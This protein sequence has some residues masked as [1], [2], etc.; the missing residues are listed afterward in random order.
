MLVTSFTMDKP[1]RSTAPAATVTVVASPS[2]PPGGRCFALYASGCGLE[3]A[4]C[5]VPSSR[6]VDPA[7]RTRT[8]EALA[9]IQLQRCVEGFAPSGPRPF[10][11]APNSERWCGRRETRSS[12]TSSKSG[13]SSANTSC[14]ASAKNSHSG[15]MHVHCF[16]QFLWAVSVLLL[17]NA[18][19][20]VFQ[21]ALTL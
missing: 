21:P 7:A 20:T 18:W 15:V 17:A 8:R 13:C 1:L 3:A 2:L 4:T 14:S 6:C 11:A 16:V 19:A 10:Q 9:Q 5:H 12:K